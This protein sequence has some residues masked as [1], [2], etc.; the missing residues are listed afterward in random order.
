[1]EIKVQ[2]E[3]PY[4]DKERMDFIVKQNHKNSYEIR[5]TEKALEA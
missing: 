4:T 5:E 3:K 2:L 1:M